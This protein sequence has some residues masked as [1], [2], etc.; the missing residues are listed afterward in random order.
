GRPETGQALGALNLGALGRG[1][2]P[3]GAAQTQVP[4]A[5][6]PRLLAQL[7]D[8]AATEAA[9]WSGESEGELAYMMDQEGAYVGDPALD[10]DRGAR[11]WILMQEA[12]AERV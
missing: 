6:F 11:L 9:G 2:I 1:T 10:R 4:A 3:V 8:Q 12:Q 7:A 5:A